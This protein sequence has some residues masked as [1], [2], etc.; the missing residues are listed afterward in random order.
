MGV[1]P[2]MIVRYEE[3]VAEKV[4][5]KLSEDKKS[6]TYTTNLGLPTKLV[7]ASL[8]AF[9]R[10]HVKSD[11]VEVEGGS[12]AAVIVVVIVIILA[13]VIAGVIYILSRRKKT[14]SGFIES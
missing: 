8:F 12:N 13:L 14:T 2:E 5:R 9:P 7:Q 1:L 3:N 11:Y 4:T 6:T 10:N